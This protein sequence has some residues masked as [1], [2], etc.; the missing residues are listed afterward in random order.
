MLENATMIAAFEGWNDAG[1]AA[2]TAA[3]YVAAAIHAV[4]LAEIDGEEFLDFTVRRPW[5]R[6]D[7]G[8]SRAIDWPV[9]R[10]S[11]GATASFAQRAQVAR[12]EPQASEDDKAGGQRPS[13]DGARELG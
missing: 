2:T 1:E 12:S 11:Y 9:T 6:A 10:V 3:R 13:G 5:V 4:P 7:A 8:G